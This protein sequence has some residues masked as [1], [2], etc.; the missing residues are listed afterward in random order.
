MEH[1]WTDEID[2]LLILVIIITNFNYNLSCSKYSKFSETAVKNHKSEKNSNK[3]NELY[4]L[5][6]KI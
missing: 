3:Y 6:F 2:S 5:F 4:V 1:F